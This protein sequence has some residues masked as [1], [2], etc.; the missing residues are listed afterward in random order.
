MYTWSTVDGYSPQLHPG[1]CWPRSAMR[2]RAYVRGAPAWASMA[3]IGQSLGT[4]PRPYRYCCLVTTPIARRCHAQV[5]QV[6]YTLSS[7]W[8]RAYEC[9]ASGMETCAPAPSYV[10]TRGVAG[11]PTTPISFP[12]PV[13]T[14][15]RPD[16]GEIVHV[17]PEGMM[18]RAGCVGFP[19]RR[20]TGPLRAPRCSRPRPHARPTRN[21]TGLPAGAGL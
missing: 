19:T 7:T 9:P 18:N 2:W 1:A 12:V 20:R 16:A 21:V 6:R 5:E 14:A 15:N 11:P 3:C 4:S 8:P 17:A 13:R 10:A